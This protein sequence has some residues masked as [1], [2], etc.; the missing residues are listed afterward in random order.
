MAVM[1]P[2]SLVAQGRWDCLYC[3][4]CQR[5]LRGLGSLVSFTSKEDGSIMVSET[6]MLDR[7]KDPADLR[8]LTDEEL[9]QVADDLRAETIN[10]VAVTGGH[11]GAGL[12]VIELTVALHHVFDTPRDNERP[13]RWPTPLPPQ[14]TV[15][16]QR[17]ENSELA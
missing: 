13:V 6:T 4:R 3:V 1:G 7:V 15:F 14:R 16:Q 12:G 11:L 17:A 9:R 5:K 2:L 10:A 8:G